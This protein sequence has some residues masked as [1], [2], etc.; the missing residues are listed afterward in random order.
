[1]KDRLIKSNPFWISIFSILSWLILF[2]FIIVSVIEQDIEQKKS[3]MDRFT[4]N[5][6]EQ[7]NKYLISN[8]TI[9]KGFSALF[10]AVG[11]TYST[12]T[13]DYAKEVIE[14]NPQI[15]A[16]EVVQ[17]V[18]NDQ[19]GSFVEDMRQNTDPDYTVKSFSYESDRKWQEL[20]E[21]PT[22]YPLVFMEPLRPGSEDVLGLDMESVPFLKRAMLDSIKNRSPVMSHPFRLI[23]GNRAYVVF[24]PITQKFNKGIVIHDELLA[25]MVVDID[26]LTMQEKIPIINGQE[27]YIYH[28]DFSHDD[29]EG[30]LLNI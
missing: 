28:N 10:A 12:E 1:M 3:Q 13:K 19:L 24:S 17:K 20:K 11:K 4:T 16:L 21:K 6:S 27:V 22:Y 8:N 23:E 29:P 30:Q 25:C 26:I 2:L 18:G 5:Y 15:Y 14:A 7:L 9:L